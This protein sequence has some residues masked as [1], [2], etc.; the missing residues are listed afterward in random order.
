M[1]KGSVFAGKKGP[2]STGYGTPVVN[3][4]GT[5]SSFFDNSL[6]HNPLSGLPRAWQATPMSSHRFPPIHH[7]QAN[8]TSSNRAHPMVASVAVANTPNSSMVNRVKPYSLQ[9]LVENLNEVNETIFAY[10]FTSFSLSRFSCSPNSP[11]HIPYV[12]ITS[13]V[14]KIYSRYSMY[15]LD[16]RR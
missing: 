7:Q 12:T 16:Y 15:V 9:G 11:F 8:S 14:L 1:K 4:S 13:T 5:S 10:Q 2:L 3:I 6:P